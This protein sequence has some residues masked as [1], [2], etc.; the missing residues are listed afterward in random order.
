[1][2][3]KATD[4]GRSASASSIIFDSL[5]QTIIDGELEER[6]PLR[7]DEIATAFNTS[8]IPVREALTRLE[9]HGLIESRRF[10]GAIVAGLSVR[11]ASQIFDFRSLL[12]GEVIA[13]AVPLMRAQSLCE[14][15]ELAASFDACEE[16]MGWGELNRKLHY[17]LYRDSDLDYHLKIIDNA[18]DRIER[19]LRVQ[20]L[21]TD[22]R[23]R[24]SREHLQIL[25]AC[26]QGD[27][28]EARRLT[29]NH[30]LGAKK[31]LIDHLEREK[32]R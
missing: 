29:R 6:A 2:K 28:E 1:M 21:L 16:P 8:R 19:Y 10:R 30:I 27:A 32:N 3:L 24:A 31:A 25:D 17:T 11:E 20:L 13:A 18:I 14:A 7:Q 5:R 9:Q 15:R 4:I 23:Q 26:E 12:E 22:G